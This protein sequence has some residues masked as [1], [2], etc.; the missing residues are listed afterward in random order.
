MVVV[1]S[2]TLLTNVNKNPQFWLISM[3]QTWCQSGISWIL[4]APLAYEVNFLKVGGM[5]ANV[6]SFERSRGLLWVFLC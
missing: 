6:K 2:V 1:S 3:P 4:L 5:V